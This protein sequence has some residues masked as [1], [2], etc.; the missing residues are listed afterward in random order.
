MSKPV[1]N[2]LARG[3]T[4]RRMMD[5]IADRRTARL[6][7]RPVRST[8]SGAPRY[9]QGPPNEGIGSPGVFVRTQNW[10]SD[11]SLALQFPSYSALPQSSEITQEWPET[12]TEYTLNLGAPVPVISGKPQF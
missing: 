5:K 8:P 12:T 3:L 9:D 6:K 7:E 2:E 11:A 4:W 1:I 10:P